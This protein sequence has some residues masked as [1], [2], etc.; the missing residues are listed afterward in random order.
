MRYSDAKVANRND[1]EI[2]GGGSLTRP[3][4]DARRFPS[5]RWYL[6]PG[7]T[8]P[9]LGFGICPSSKGHSLCRA[10]NLSVTVFAPVASQGEEAEAARGCVDC[11]PHRTPGEHGDVATQAA[12]WVGTPRPVEFEGPCSN[13]C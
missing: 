5:T 13:P 3:F 7:A 6:V 11:A 2:S 8:R 9:T 12:A 4:R 10:V 1:R